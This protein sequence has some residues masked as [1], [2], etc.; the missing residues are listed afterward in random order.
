MAESSI[1]IT[2]TITNTGSGSKDIDSGALTN[3]D[4]PVAV[5][6][7]R[8]NATFAAITF[9][10]LV[11]SAVAKGVYIKPLNGSGTITLKGVTGDTGWAIHNTEPTFIRLASATSS[12]GGI[13]TSADVTFEFVWV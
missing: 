6:T 1:R 11:G 3:S 12:P 7:Q 8:I 4:C 10:A 5:T 2:G 9:P 13:T